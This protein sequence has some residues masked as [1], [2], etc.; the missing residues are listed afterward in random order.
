[1]KLHREIVQEN[2][3][4]IPH[5][6]ILQAI[7]KDGDVTDNYQVY[8]LALVSEFFKNGVKNLRDLE[9]PIPYSNNATHTDVIEAIKSLSPSDKVN[10]AQYLL[11][12]IAAGESLF[13]NPQQSSADWIRFVLRKQD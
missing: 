5:T 3:G 12:C 7:I 13:H 6:L 4:P 2:Q 8:V 10:L 11:D 1:M 9:A